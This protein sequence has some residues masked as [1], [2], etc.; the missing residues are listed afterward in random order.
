MK[1]RNF[2]MLPDRL[3]TK[4]HREL[5][6]SDGKAESVAKRRK[7][8][9]LSEIVRTSQF[10]QQ[11]QDIIDEDSSMSIRAI[12][13]NLQVFECTIRRIVHE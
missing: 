2:L 1:Y 12:S 8:K 3:F 7:H 4:V 13:R 10:V 11:V 6:A 9:P 5:E